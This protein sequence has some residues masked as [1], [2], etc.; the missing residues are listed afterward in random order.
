M[1]SSFDV[2]EFPIVGK[3]LVSFLYDTNKW[4]LSRG[5]YI[6]MYKIENQETTHGIYDF[7]HE[8]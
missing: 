3:K 1:L 6:P 2:F 4:L 8:K 7:F 5:K